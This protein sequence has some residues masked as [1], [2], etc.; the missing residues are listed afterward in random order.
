MPLQSVINVCDGH[1]TFAHYF[2]GDTQ[3]A[4]QFKGPFWTQATWQQAERTKTSRQLPTHSWHEPTAA[5]PA[6]HYPRQ[7]ADSLIWNLRRGSPLKSRLGWVGVSLCCGVAAPLSIGAKGC[8]WG[9]MAGLGAGGCLH[10]TALYLKKRQPKVCVK[11][12]T[13]CYAV[14]G[15]Y[16]VGR[17]ICLAAVHNTTTVTRTHRALLGPR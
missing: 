16:R 13:V 3:R 5:S 8:P 1:T 17:W 4:K 11:Y 10:S 6:P 12:H 9:P 7:P 15:H 2:H 14:R